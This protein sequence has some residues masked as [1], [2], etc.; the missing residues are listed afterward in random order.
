MDWEKEIQ[1]YNGLG[2]NKENII[3]FPHRADPEKQPELFEK[4][5]QKVNEYAIVNINFNEYIKKIKDY[6]EVINMLD[7]KNQTYVNNLIKKTSHVLDEKS[8]MIIGNMT[9]TG[10]SSWQT[11]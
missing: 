3:V 6:P 9:I 11:L 10:K 2:Q 4:I 5:M 7:S 1:K 8:E